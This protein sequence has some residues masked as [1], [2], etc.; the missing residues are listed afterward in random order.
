MMTLN[1]F[2]QKGG[3]CHYSPNM[4]VTDK[5]VSMDQLRIRFG[6]YAQVWE[7]STQTNSMNMRRHGAIALGPSPTSTTSYLF[8]ALDTGKII[9]R[10]QF[11]EIPITAS[12]I[13]HVNQLGSGKPAML[14]WTNRC[15]ETIGDGP[16]WD[17]TETRNNDASTTSAVAEAMEEDDD[18]VVVVAK[19]DR[20]TMPT[21]DVDVVDNIAGVDTGTQDVYKVWNE[22]VPDNVGDVDQIN[23]DVKVTEKLAS[24]GVTTTKWDQLLKVIPQVTAATK[25]SPTGTG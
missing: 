25:V 15:S 20:V 17:T 11:T 12:V 18:N 14:T 23:Y 22:D 10:A 19:E 13:E 21:T 9:N 7:P 16:L 24:G 8:L 5:G 4:I 1:M 3:N 6:S 2:L